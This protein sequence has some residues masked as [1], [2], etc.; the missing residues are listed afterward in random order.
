MIRNA[1]PETRSLL[2]EKC[3]L[4]W[5]SLIIPLF[6]PYTSVSSII[7]P[8]L[9]LLASTSSFPLSSLS[10]FPFSFLSSF[11]PL[12]LLYFLLGNLLTYM[13]CSFLSE[14]ERWREAGRK[15]FQRLDL[16]YRQR[17]SAGKR[18]RAGAGCYEKVA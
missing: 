16:D 14:Y 11:L 15:R 8:S 12:Q 17:T 10:S 13:L 6:P 5:A 4:G 7:L 9:S 18:T 1:R 3:L 2:S